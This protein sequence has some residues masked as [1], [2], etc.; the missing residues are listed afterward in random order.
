MSELITHGC[1][2][3]AAKSGAVLAGLARG[4]AFLDSK[5]QCSTEVYLDF[6]G[7]AKSARELR[8]SGWELRVT[9]NPKS[10]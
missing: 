4:H 3:V 7:W 1:L 10:P 2:V 8:A 6:G 5:G 9:Y